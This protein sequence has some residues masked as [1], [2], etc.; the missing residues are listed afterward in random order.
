MSLY[1]EAR[2]N[3]ALPREILEAFPTDGASHV[4]CFSGTGRQPKKSLAR[5][6]TGKRFETANS[7]T[8]CSKTHTT[9]IWF[10]F[11]TINGCFCQALLKIAAPNLR[12]GSFLH[13]PFHLQSIL[14]FKDSSPQISVCRLTYR[15]DRLTAVTL[16]PCD[17]RGRHTLPGER[18]DRV[19]AR[20][21]G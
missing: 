8:R 20:R 5:G 18:R 19:P 16:F 9:A 15:P 11:M 21:L 13:T 12:I 1:P 2:M 3:L 14:L 7:P 17:G 10:E 6:A 4:R